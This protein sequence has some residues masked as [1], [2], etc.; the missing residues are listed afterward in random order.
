[1]T[2]PRLF[3]IALIFLMT[4]AAWFILGTSV[5]VRTGESDSRL[6]QEVRQLWGGEHVQRAPEAWFEVTRSVIDPPKDPNPDRSDATSSSTSPAVKTVVIRHPLTLAS[7]Q[8]DAALSLDERQKGLLWYATYGVT[9]QGDYRLVNTDAERREVFVRFSFPSTDAL[10]DGFL[11]RL[12]GR[13]IGVGSDLSQGIVATVDLP[14][15]GEAALSVSYRSR[16]LGDWAYAFAPTG[17]GRVQD[18]SLRLRSDCDGIDFPA[19]TVSPTAKAR[20]GAGWDLGWTFKSLVTG[21]R[22]GVRLPHRLNPGPLAARVTFFAPVGLLFFITVLVVLGILS[23]RSLHPMN[24]FF[25][26]AAFF[27]FHL[28][29]AY[30]A[31]HLN[32]H[33]SFVIASLTS[34][35]LVVSYLRL[36]GGMRFACLQAGAAQLLYLVLFSYAFFLEGYTG[37]TVTI[38]AIV[39]LFVLMTVTARVDWSQVFAR[40]PLERQA[41]GS[42]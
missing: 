38:G 20:A 31:D 39:T 29:L 22:I 8:I 1:M 9:F 40:P 7:S 14:P 15:G 10:Y 6:E 18:F 33:A 36:I 11:F 30:L 21:Q 3:A 2:V 19:G 28:L 24:Y 41:A 26:S 16:G 37:L 34:I 42:R 35:A 13:E 27:S 17:V 4:T 32:I 12:N 5:V 25:V 23:G